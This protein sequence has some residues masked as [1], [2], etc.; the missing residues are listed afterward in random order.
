MVPQ[1]CNS[2]N[3]INKWF[4]H[5]KLIFFVII[6]YRAQKNKKE[7]TFVYSFTHN[8]K[9]SKQSLKG[10]NKVTFSPLEVL[11][12]SW[13]KDRQE[14]RFRHCLCCFHSGLLCH[15]WTCTA[16]DKYKI[17]D[18]VSGHGMGFL[19]LLFFPQIWWSQ[20]PT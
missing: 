10:N 6:F 17:K 20:L 3:F 12:V 1:Q 19:K 16:K 8:T 15:Y 4:P 11:W 2:I 9:V 5:F 14:C 18:Q 13:F 7:K